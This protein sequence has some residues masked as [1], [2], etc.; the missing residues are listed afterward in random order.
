MNVAGNSGGGLYSASAIG[1]LLEGSLI[2]EN[3]PDWIE[4]EWIDGTGNDFPVYCPT[5]CPGD[6]DSDGFVNVIDVL[7][8]IGDWGSCPPQSPCP[9]DF[10]DDDSVNVS[11]LLVVIDNWGPCE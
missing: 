9:G 7:G 3:E 8:L 11:D 10:N 2:C 6:F 4:G 1:I 5:D